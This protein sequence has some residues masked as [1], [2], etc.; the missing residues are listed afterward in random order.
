MTPF[1]AR[2]PEVHV[3]FEY[4]L[5]TVSLKSSALAVPIKH[6]HKTAVTSPVGLAKVEFFIFYQHL[7]N[8]H[9]GP[10]NPSF[11]PVTIRFYSMK[12]VC[13]GHIFARARIHRGR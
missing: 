2:Y 9:L 4:S 11:F 8:Y 10:R 5:D 7:R 12:K 13:P 6:R 1:T 3:A